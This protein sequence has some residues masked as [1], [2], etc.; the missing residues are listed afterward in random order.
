MIFQDPGASLNPVLTVGDQIAQQLRCHLK[1][2]V[3]QAWSRAIELLHEVGIPSPALRVSAYPHELSGGQKQRVMIAMAISCEP[4]L[5]I[6]DEPTSALD[7]TVQR[8]IL[9]LLGRLKEDHGLSM[10]FITHDLAAAAEVSDQVVVMRQGEVVET[11]DKTLLLSS[12]KNE[13]TSSLVQARERLNIPRSKL[14]ARKPS[15][16]GC[17]AKPVVVAEGLR[18]EY[19]IRTGLW[20]RSILT[21]VDSVSFSLSRGETLGVVGESGSGKTTMARMLVR[22]IAAT[23]GSVSLDGQQILDMSLRE[24]R[25]VRKRI[26]IVFQNPYASLNPRWTI[27]RALTAPM[28][29]HGLGVT[30][31]DRDARAAHLLDRVGLSS[32]AMGKLPHQFSG[33]ERQRI[34]IARCLGVEPEILICDECVSALDVSVQAQVLNLLQELQAE[35]NLAYLFISHDMAVIRHISDRVLVMEGGKIVESGPTEIVFSSPSHPYT[36]SL[37]EAVLTPARQAGGCE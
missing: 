9:G 1:L 12:S 16:L 37:L 36:C 3:A 11:G 13:Y 5:L 20:R 15:K 25:L 30:P 24:F 19:S 22:L 29:V 28:K 26:Q 32:D 35:Y 4:K 17:A 8:K 2:S 34:A 21:A 7:A 33:G 10:L 18:K 6:A 31:Q 27:Q 14:V 23:G